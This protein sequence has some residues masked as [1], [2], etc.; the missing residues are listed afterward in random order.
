MRRTFDVSSARSDRGP[1]IVAP[2]A[3]DI[4]VRGWRRAADRTPDPAAV[5]RPL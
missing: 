4:N 1:G 5:K 2:G 3:E